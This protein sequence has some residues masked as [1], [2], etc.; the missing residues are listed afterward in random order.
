VILTLEITSPQPGKPG[1]AS[2][3]TFDGAGGT[4]GREKDNSWV[5]PHSK[6]SGHHALITYRN[7]VYYI[8]DTSRNGVCLNSSRN[9]L[10]RGRPSPLSSGDRILIDPYEIQVSIGGDQREP[11]GRHPSALADLRFDSSDPFDTSDDPFAPRPFPSSGLD[12]PEE[13]IAGQ[14]VDPLEL[15]NLAPPKRAPARQAPRARD[16]DRGSILDQHYQPPDVLSG[17]PSVPRADPMSIPQGYD[18]LAPDTSQDFAPF[19][20]RESPSLPP[21]LPPTF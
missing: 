13:A 15:L 21:P 3:H 17:S 10:E 16:L 11:A 14:E 5:L 8:E 20:P 2:R 6:V 4:I 18:P 12:A 1:G 7:A 9:R 19:V